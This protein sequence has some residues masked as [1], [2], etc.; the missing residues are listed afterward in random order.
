MTK[1]KPLYDKVLS[2]PTFR[3][4]LEKDPSAAL[5]FVGIDPTPKVLEA[6][7]GVTQAVSKLGRDIGAA[8]DEMKE[9]VS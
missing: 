4:W 1:F 8:A 7:K 3:A 6:V 5:R 9:C 2:D